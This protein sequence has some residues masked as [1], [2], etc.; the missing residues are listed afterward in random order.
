MRIIRKETACLV[1]TE[2][3]PS[4]LDRSE[5]VDHGPR[6]F[7]IHQHAVTEHR[8]E[9]LPSGISF[10]PV[11]LF[12]TSK[13]H[14]VKGYGLGA[15]GTWNAQE[16]QPTGGILE[17]IVEDLRENPVALPDGEQRRLTS[18]SGGACRWKP[19]KTCVG[20]SRGRRKPSTGPGPG[21]GIPS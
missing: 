14:V 13:E 2:T 6:V 18:F 8:V 11:I 15:E 4:A 5:S 19:G 9:P 17:R 1:R 20:W 7:Q 3:V 21:E 16:G 10:L 12:S